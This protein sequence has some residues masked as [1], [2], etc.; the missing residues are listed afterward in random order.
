[1]KIEIELKK[2]EIM[3]LEEILD[4]ELIDDV[5]YYYSEDEISDAIRTLLEYI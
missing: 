5:G 1:M 2:S 3:K 4:I